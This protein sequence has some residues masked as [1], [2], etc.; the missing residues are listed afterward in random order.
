M[1]IARD[2]RHW[3]LAL[4]VLSLLVSLFD[5]SAPANS[6]Q[7]RACY[8]EGASAQGDLEDGQKDVLRRFGKFDYE[9]KQ[10][11]FEALSLWGFEQQPTPDKTC[12]RYEIKNHS[13]L[14]LEDVSWP[15]I[16]MEFIDIAVADR[17][18]WTN[19]A[20][21]PHPALKDMSE[22]KAFARSSDMIRA[23]LNWRHANGAAGG[24]ENGGRPRL[25]ALERQGLEFGRAEA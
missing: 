11:R 2:A 25:L 21:P 8:A 16:G 10:Y 9:G 4:F 7:V 14:R 3:K 22:I 13:G 15:D 12:F 23:Y 19:P 18:H 5:L 6:Q 17:S 1:T 24:P 20:I